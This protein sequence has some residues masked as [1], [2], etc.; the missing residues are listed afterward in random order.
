[1]NIASGA[2]AVL[3]VLSSL[4]LGFTLWL[5]NSHQSAFDESF[6]HETVKAAIKNNLNLSASFEFIEKALL[7]QYPRHIHLGEPWLFN[8]A[9]GFKSGMKLLHASI[10]ECN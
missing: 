5:M 2:V 3:A 8:C 6:L 4:S 10:S 1:M 9:G 7:Q